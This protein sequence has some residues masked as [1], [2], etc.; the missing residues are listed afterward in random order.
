MVWVGIEVGL[1]GEREHAVIVHTEADLLSL[2]RLD[3][4]VLYSE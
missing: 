1:V 3:Y 4:V 2:Q